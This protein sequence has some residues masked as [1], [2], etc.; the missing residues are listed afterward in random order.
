VKVKESTYFLIACFLVGKSLQVDI[1]LRRQTRRV[2]TGQRMSFHKKIISMRSA[3][4]FF[5]QTKEDDRLL[6][7]AFQAVHFTFLNRI[8]S[9]LGILSVSGSMESTVWRT[10]KRTANVRNKRR[11]VLFG[12]TLCSKGMGGT[13]IGARSPMSCS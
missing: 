13:S 12:K 6:F 9:G 4:I 11:P 8:G 3:L 7:N 2:G 5:L 1:T 10:D